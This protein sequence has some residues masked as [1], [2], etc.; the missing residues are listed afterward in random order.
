MFSTVWALSFQNEQSVF[1]GQPKHEFDVCLTVPTYFF[2]Q[3]LQCKI[4][5]VQI[6]ITVDSSLPSLGFGFFSCS[7]TW[8]RQYLVLHL[9]Q[10]Q[11]YLMEDSLA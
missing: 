10:S 8:H 3:D 6:A 9:L 2:Q 11:N 5:G 4:T 1:S 7:K